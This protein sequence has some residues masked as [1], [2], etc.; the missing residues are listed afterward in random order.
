M[1]F[2]Y[3]LSVRKQ[4]FIKFYLMNR[5]RDFYDQKPG[6]FLFFHS[7]PF[8]QERRLETSQHSDSEQIQSTFTYANFLQISL[9]RGSLS[10]RIHSL[11]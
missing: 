5:Y 2:S 8:M 6:P 4:Y 7:G 11:I 3:I 1:E 9:S 10:G